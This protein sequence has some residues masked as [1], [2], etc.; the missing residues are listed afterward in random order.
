ERPDAARALVRRGVEDVGVARVHHDLGDAGVLAD[1]E[2]GVPRLAAVGGLVEPALAAG[3]P[4]RA[5]GGHVHH[6]RIPRVDD[7]PADVLG[8]LEA[9]VLPALAGVVGA[10]DA[11]PVRDAP[12]AV[13]FAGAHPD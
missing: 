4:E 9:H 8:A 6:A 10:V 13:V 1:E 3:L 11:V 2:H 7:D 12:L 5:L